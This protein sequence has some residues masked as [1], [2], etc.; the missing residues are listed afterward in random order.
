M[1]STGNAGQGISNLLGA[2]ESNISAYRYNGT[3]APSQYTEGFRRNSRPDVE[4]YGFTTNHY[5]PPSQPS[6][7]RISDSHSLQDKLRRAT[8]STGTPG[9]DVC[10]CDLGCGLEYPTSKTSQHLNLYHGDLER[11]GTQIIC[12]V[13]REKITEDNFARHIREVHH[14][15]EEVQCPQCRKTFTRKSNLSRH[16]KTH[17]SPPGSGS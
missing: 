10:D 13:H 7:P 2:C 6:T 11:D 9:K 12:P 3:L 1:I 8:S 5:V 16:M 15:C 14:K 17:Q 4:V